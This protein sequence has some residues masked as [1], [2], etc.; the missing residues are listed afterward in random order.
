MSTQQIKEDPYKT[1]EVSRYAT[2]DQIT[3]SYK[4]LARLRHPDKQPGNP[5]AATAAFQALG[6]AYDIL[7]DASKRREYD[8]Q[9]P[10]NTTRSRTQNPTTDSRRTTPSTSQSSQRGYPRATPSDSQ[11]TEGSSTRTGS[12]TDY[13]FEEHM[14]VVRA[15]LRDRDEVRQIRLI[16][17]KRSQT[18]QATK[19]AHDLMVPQV[20]EKIAKFKAIIKSRR[21]VGGSCLDMEDELRVSESE[22]TMVEDS[23]PVQCQNFEYDQS[24]DQSRIREIE[25]RMRQRTRNDRWG[26]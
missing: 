3:Q 8:L 11:Y 15:N 6:A 21:A 9:T 12:Y 19:T 14:K 22:L 17:F 13:A 23:F 16:M 20:K 2:Q 24:V 10:Q 1:L 7:K 25:E 4:R 18:W 5:Q 26:S